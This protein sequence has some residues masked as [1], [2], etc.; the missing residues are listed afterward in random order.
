VRKNSESA[1]HSSMKNATFEELL[2]F[3]QVPETGPAV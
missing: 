3:L 2:R 1:K